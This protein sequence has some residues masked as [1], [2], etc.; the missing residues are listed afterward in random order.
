[1]TLSLS[2]ILRVCAED[3]GD[4]AT[5]YVLA[6]LDQ[7]W[8]QWMMQRILIPGWPADPNTAEMSL[9]LKLSSASVDELR[10]ALD[11]GTAVPDRTHHARIVSATTLKSSIAPTN[12]REAL[13]MHNSDRL[14][15]L[16]AYKEEYDALKGLDTFT[17]IDERQLQQ[18]VQRGCE[19]V[20]S[21]TVFTVK[22][23]KSGKPYR[24][25]ARTVA[26]GN[27]ERR[28]WT[29]ED[30]YAPVLSQVG[31]RLLASEAVSKGRMLKQADCKNAFCQP[32]LPDDEVVIVIP[33]K[34]CPFTSP[35]TYWKLNKTLYGLSRSPK[36]WY[37]KI[38]GALIELGFTPC[39]HDTCLWRTNP[40]DGT[41]PVYVGL[42]VDDFVY[43]SESDEQEA[44]FEAAM[45]DRFTVDFMGPVDYFLG[46]RYEWT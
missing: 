10:E 11:D 6:D 29:K 37:E 38:T 12:L 9:W 44:W 43:F 32:D 30:K 36:H 3:I 4:G 22:P 18:Y 26:L 19:V 7:N 35:G 42:Y 46:C 15:W 20:P 2:W 5:E 14:I 33:P 17:E 31:A 40:T 41:A 8:R 39:D 24:A 23:D 13:K 27:L 21:M 45:K 1:M 16:A 34:G 25:K 28:T